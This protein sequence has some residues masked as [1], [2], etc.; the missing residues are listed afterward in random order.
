MII[1]S[2]LGKLK[3]EEAKRCA[4]RCGVSVVDEQP[5]T[6][7]EQL[8]DPHCSGTCWFSTVQ[9]NMASAAFVA[10]LTLC[11]VVPAEAIPLFTSTT[12]TPTST[13]SGSCTSTCFCSDVIDADSD[14]VPYDEYCAIGSCSDCTASCYLTNKC[15][16]DY[17]EYCDPNFRIL[18]SFSA[19]VGN[20]VGVSSGA[21]QRT[22][23]CLVDAEV[24]ASTTYELDPQSNCLLGC[25]QLS[26]AGGYDGFAASWEV[27]EVFEQC[28]SDSNHY[29]CFCSLI[30]GVIGGTN[31][32]SRYRCYTASTCSDGMSNGAETGI[33]C[34]GIDCDPCPCSD[35]D[36]DGI[37]DD[38][39][40]CVQN[41][42]NDQDSD[43][44]CAGE[45]PSGV[46]TQIPE[47]AATVADQYD[48]DESVCAFSLGTSGL[49]S[50][51]NFSTVTVDSFD[52]C[53]GACVNDENCT[54]FAVP[55]GTI[56]ASSCFLYVLR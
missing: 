6:T 44:L 22:K 32:V 12:S 35:I 25:A 41:F 3:R 39:D 52:E 34:G 13:D 11:A 54:F 31:S 42:F 18:T 53:H 49:C 56:N 38:D 8:T 27:S 5:A 4:R 24:N 36:R 50:N 26:E 37:C 9:K 45:A 40:S 55:S 15:C 48:G 14:G 46:P 51:T 20:C 29:T 7:V 43:G 17:L 1:F 47:C 33:D 28:P 2:R 21:L 23:E 16:T 30:D 19:A 10:A